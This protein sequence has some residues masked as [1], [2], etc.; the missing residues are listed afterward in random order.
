MVTKKLSLTLDG[1]IKDKVKLISDNKGLSVNGYLM[2]LLINDLKKN[3]YPDIDKKQINYFKDITEKLS[4]FPVG[5][6]FTIESLFG[7]QNWNQISADE[8]RVLGKDFAKKV[9]AGNFPNV[10]KIGKDS[11]NKTWYQKQ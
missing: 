8:R 5:I 4:G 2:S 7:N 3:G 10:K 6:D 9:A 1:E 11:S